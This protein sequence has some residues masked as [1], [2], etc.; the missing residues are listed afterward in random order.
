MVQPTTKSE[1]TTLRKITASLSVWYRASRPFTL[2]AAVVPPLVGSALAFYEHKASLLL[3]ALILIASLLVQIAANLVDEYSDHSRP[4]GKEKL[5]APYKVIALGL[6]S[7]QA[8]KRGAII[9]LGIATIIGIYLIK[10]T[11][12]PVLVLCLTS[13]AAAY[14]YSAGPRPLGTIGLGHPLVF[15]F[16]GPVMVAGSYYIQTG[17]VDA[18]SIWLSVAVGSTV[19]GILAANDLRDLEE[20]RGGRKITP[21]TLFGR[22]FGRWEWTGLTALA[23]AVVILEVAVGDIGPLALISWLALPQA[24]TSA[25]AVWRGKSRP[26]L[27]V[28]LRASSKLHLYFGVL[29][30]A[31]LA[32]ERLF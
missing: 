27:A 3:F 11:G 9:C 26:E 32:A 6:L 8:V 23:F 17:S 5:L 7:S 31:G 24:I 22:T 15:I 12:W 16:M 14:L 4:E 25:R 10:V 19:T 20:D 1:N 28:A 2:S 21:V 18:Q 13:L 30:A 29:L